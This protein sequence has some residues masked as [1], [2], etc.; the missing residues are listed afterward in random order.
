MDVSIAPDSTSLRRTAT[1]TPPAVSANTPV[2]RASSRMPSR[3]SS[4]VTAAIAPPVE[5]TASS[6]YGPSAGLPML[7][8]FAIPVG[9]TGITSDAPDSNATAIGE[10]P[11]DCAPNTRHADAG[12]SAAATSSLN[13]LWILVNIDP[14]AIGATY[15]PGSRQPN[16]SATS[17]PSVFDPSA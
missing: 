16:C 13:A 7:S 17:K 1:V 14:D 15:W 3:I 5:R 2:V 4:S 8:D 10:H 12:T 11:A 9:L 6:A